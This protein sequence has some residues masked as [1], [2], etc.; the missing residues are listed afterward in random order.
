M[1]RV[2]AILFAFVRIV[3]ELHCSIEFLLPSCSQWHYLKGRVARVDFLL[4]C[5]G[6][7]QFFTSS[8]R[9]NTLHVV[10]DD[11]LSARALAVHPSSGETF[12][13]TMVAYEV[14]HRWNQNSVR[15]E[16]ER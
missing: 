1:Q 4:L 5:E 16:D 13:I 15:G 11:A 6:C 9:T 8:L 2:S 10:L 3:S 14:V 7:K 12:T